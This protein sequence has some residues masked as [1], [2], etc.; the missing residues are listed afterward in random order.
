MDL[1]L[2]LTGSV[3]TGLLTI[4]MA[5][6]M[7]QVTEHFADHGN[8]R[9]VAQMLMVLP[10]IGVVCAGPL[11]GSLIDRWSVRHVVLW[12][13]LLYTI[14]GIVSFFADSM[15]ILVVSRVLLGVAGSGIYAGSFALI[16]ERFQGARRQA[17]LGY[18]G[19][20]G[21][22]NATVVVLSAGFIGQAWGWRAVFVLY[23][24]AI[25]VFLMA[26]GLKSE[27][28]EQRRANGRPA[29]G[30]LLPLWPILVLMVLIF[31]L[32][33]S[34][35]A[36]GGHLFAE[37]GMAT[38][39][40]VAILMACSSLAYMIASALYGTIIRVLE[41]TTT[42]RLGLFLFGVGLAG[43]AMSSGV[44][45]LGFWMFLLGFGNGMTAPYLHN[46]VLEKA[47]PEVRGTASGFVSPAHYGGEFINPPIFQLLSGLGSIAASFLMLAVAS[48][49]GA[50]VLR[51]GR[52]GNRR[53]PAEEC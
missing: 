45:A 52:W 22:G 5:P 23:L 36:Q 9:I 2:M 8:A 44:V 28:R 49:A 38:A 7:P 10:C 20:V 41:P 14:C 46:L 51:P 13:S 33:Y 32:T 17:I 27:R 39:G 53:V 50:L 29:M 31:S 34:P 18:K 37:K 3:F 4:V 40:L 48:V 24:L 1:I 6:I 25:P 47:A 21:A 43:V 19:A 16:G 15:A 42:F 26:L 12:S 30:Q 35:L 11:M